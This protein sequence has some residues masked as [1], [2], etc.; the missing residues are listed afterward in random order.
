[1]FRRLFDPQSG[2]MITMTQITDCIFLSLFWMLCC[3][4]VVTVGAAFAALYDASFRSMRQ[5]EKNSWKR[6]L[7]VLRT[8]WKI[9][10]VPG[11]VVVLVLI[12]RIRELKSDETDDLDNY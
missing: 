4:P 12:Q 5:G 9:G 8:N 1:M 3:F 6:F 11:F 7:H 2:L 10:I